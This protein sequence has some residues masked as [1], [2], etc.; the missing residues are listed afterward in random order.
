[1]L[2]VSQ[3]SSPAVTLLKL[4]KSGGVVMREKEERRNARDNRI[5]E[6]FYGHTN[7]LLPNTESRNTENLVVYRVG[8]C[9]WLKQDHTVQE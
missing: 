1:M 7:N 3:G 8:E 2:T 6:Y 9:Q 4:T 5:R